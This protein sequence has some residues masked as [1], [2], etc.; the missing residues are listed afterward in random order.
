MK[1]HRKQ[2]VD[3]LGQRRLVD[4]PVD[5][6]LYKIDRR[7]DYLNSRAK[8]KHIAFDDRFI[9]DLAADVADVYERSQLLECLREALQKLDKD[10]RLL[11]EYYYYDNLDEHETAARMKL[12]QSTVNRKKHR[13]I[14]KLRICL[15]D[16]L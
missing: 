1:K 5:D 10:E 8:A 11:V 7:D 2:L 9:A 4:V 15:S 16:W 12:S 14:E 13:I 3:V 6:E